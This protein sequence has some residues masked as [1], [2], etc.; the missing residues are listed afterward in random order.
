MHAHGRALAERIPG[1]PAAAPVIP[2]NSISEASAAAAA[3]AE[4]ASALDNA[5]HVRTRPPSFPVHPKGCRQAGLRPNCPPVFCSRPWDRRR[6]LG[7]SPAARP[8]PGITLIIDHLNKQKLA[9]QPIIVGS[10]HI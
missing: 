7:P 9:Q 6:Q 3:A 2:A 4:L 1:K 10:S 8:Q 5:G